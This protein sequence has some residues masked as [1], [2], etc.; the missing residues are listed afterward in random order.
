MSLFLM[1][2]QTLLFAVAWATIHFRV[3]AGGPIAG[4]QEFTRWNNRVYSVASLLLLCIIQLPHY[5]DTAK[6]IYHYSKFYEY[7][8]ILGVRSS[9]G[10]IDLHFAVHH[11]TTP[12][13]TYFRVLQHSDGWQIVAS[14]NALHHVFM[15]AY[16]GG[17]ASAR[18][19]LPVTGTHN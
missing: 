17:I 15:Y 10:M 3:K 2:V 5:S 14:L 19:L 7:I 8:D 12:Y 11:L 6:R 13:F 1:T 16:F 18:R 9:G 4:A